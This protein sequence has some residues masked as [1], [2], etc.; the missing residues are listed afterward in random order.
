[1]LESTKAA[2]SCFLCFPSVYLHARVMRMNSELLHVVRELREK[3]LQ[4]M[5]VSIWS[6]FELSKGLA[7]E[8]DEL[9]NQQNQQNLWEQRQTY[10][11]FLMLVN[12]LKT[13]GPASWMDFYM[14]GCNERIFL[15]KK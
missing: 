5:P 10:S 4:L 2:R 14:T 15:L 8:K 1:M 11:L 12:R 3:A 7:L 6:C 9:K 13:H